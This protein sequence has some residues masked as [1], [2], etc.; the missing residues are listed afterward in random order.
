[1]S[2]TP[3]QMRGYFLPAALAYLQGELGAERAQQLKDSFSPGLK[4]AIA[5]ARPVDWVPIEMMEEI[6]KVV[7]THVAEE[8]PVRAQECLTQLG[9]QI[10][11]VATGTFLRLL[12]KILTPE[13][14]AKRLPH[15]MSRDFSGGGKV[16]VDVSQSRIRL[17]ME[18]FRSNLIGPISVGFLSTALE[19]MGKEVQSAKIHEWSL[20]ASPP[21]TISL[22]VVWK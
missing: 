2:G 15:L 11:R 9:R 6:A 12:M 8:D 17:W 1:M 21:E 14:F 7:V 13:L 19:A 20:T 18:D 5:T 3:I 22:E 4:T 16:R 10:A